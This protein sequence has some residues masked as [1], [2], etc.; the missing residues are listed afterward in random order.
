M[1]KI[2]LPVEEKNLQN[3]PRIYFQK[4]IVCVIPTTAQAGQLFYFNPDGNIDNSIVLGLQFLPQDNVG[5]KTYFLVNNNALPPNSKQ[6]PNADASYTLITL[7]NKKDEAIVQDY[8]V[9]GL[10]NVVNANVNRVVRY[11]T[12][13]CLKK[14]FLQWQGNAPA[15]NLYFYFSIF[16]KPK[17]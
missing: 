17:N 5:S 6:S 9:N 3:F 11:H 13:I 7:K 2:I 12:E 10:A 4:Q 15:Q 8:P 14:C 16:Y 1:K